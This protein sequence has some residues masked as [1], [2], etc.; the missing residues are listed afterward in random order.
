MSLGCIHGV[1]NTDN[2]AISGETIDYGPYAFMDTFHPQ[3]VYSS[4]DSGGR[5]AWGNQPAI[6]LWNMTR[7]AETLLPLL[8]ENRDEA[9]RLAEA[10]LAEFPERFDG[11]YTAR[12]RAK[13]GLP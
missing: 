7:F 5:Y 8:S 3:C 13:F 12:F 2:T 9:I 10:C 11:Q 6:G 1:M 4:I